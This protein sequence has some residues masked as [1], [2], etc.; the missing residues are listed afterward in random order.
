MGRF[1]EYM[2]YFE[3]YRSQYGDRTTVLYQCGMFY[4][5][6]G[7]E[8]E[9]E[10][11]GHASEIA[12][13]LNIQLTRTDK[14]VLENN[15]SNP[16]MT[17]FPCA[18]IDRNVQILIDNGYTVVIVD[19]VSEKMVGSKKIVT[20]DVT[21]IHSPSTYVNSSR[22]ENY[23]LSI[24]VE[25]NTK[26]NK[27]LY[28]IGLTAIDL[29]TGRVYA[30]QTISKESDLSSSLDETYR[31]VQTF[32]PTE[33]VLS[34]NGNTKSLPILDDFLDTAKDGIVIHDFDLVSRP[35]FLQNS[36]HNHFL[37]SYY[38]TGVL[39]PVQFLDLEMYRSTTV[40]FCVMIQFCKDHNKS[41]LSKLHTPT[42]WDNHKTL[43]LD[44][45]AIN[46]LNLLPPKSGS[47][48]NTSIYG[49]VNETSTSMGRRL[50]KE[51]LL[52]PIINIEELNMRYDYIDMMLTEHEDLTSVVAKKQKQQWYVTVEKLLREIVDVER[53]HRK[54]ETKTLQPSE[55]PMVASGYTATITLIDVIRKNQLFTKLFPE[56]VQK[57][58][59]DMVE[60]YSNVIDLN[61]VGKYNIKDITGNFFKRGYNSNLDKIDDI[62]KLNKGLLE[63]LA[64][65]LSKISKGSA[66]DHVT[67]KCGEDGYYLNTSKP[68]F[69]AIETSF[70]PFV[71]SDGTKID[72]L[73][74]FDIDNRTKTN[75]KIRGGVMESI[76]KKVQ[77]STDNLKAKVL[78]AYMI[79]L[80]DL[81]DKFGWVFAKVTNGLAEL[82]VY[83]SSAK[84][85]DKNKYTRPLLSINT[86]ASF[87]VI[88][89]RH[90]IVEKLET[91]NQYVANSFKLA[92][93]GMLLYGINA[94]GK[95]STMK[96]VGI[97]VVM[98][99]A[100]MYVAAEKLN[101]APFR[102]IMTRILGNDNILKGLSSFAVEMTELR[103]IISRADEYSL[104]LGDE[105]CHG[106]ETYSGI[107][108]V[109]AS[110]IHLSNVG[111]TFIFAT[112][113][114]QLSSMDEILSLKN[115][116]Q[117]HLAAYHDDAT[118]EL[119]YNR[120]LM[121]G[122]GE[123]MYGIEVAKAMKLPKQLIVAATTIRKKYFTNDKVTVSLYNK[124]VYVDKCKIC[125]DKAVETHHIKFQ[126][127]SDNN[128]Y[129]DHQHKNHKSNLV[130]LCEKHHEMVHC[131]ADKE[132]IVFG[133]YADGSLDYTFRNPLRSFK[134]TSV[135]S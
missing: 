68:R 52:N 16:L 13:L 125:D 34:R 44:N 58:I 4:E 94:S 64:L 74:D 103:G 119:I 26:K 102:T 112:H 95:S 120:K 61:E 37:K 127:E 88:N 76:D 132:L 46:Q 128:G 130:Q 89:M 24:F 117:C 62:V 105:I 2:T 65:A 106:T 67:L 33:I 48:R 111:S 29:G 80:S 92:G 6:Y 5:V 31:F 86:Q 84:C 9:H 96:A 42:I 51:R 99:Q 38:S 23:L 59:T 131:P 87:D 7:I 27:V 60:F 135:V 90:P 21:A 70:K 75:T 28:D 1:D 40:A 114:Q 109:A 129:I 113:L 104:V 3:K 66:S 49:I 79:F 82:D 122:S 97:A 19:Q 116:R 10:R 100:G 93:E 25:G 15:R 39:D 20:R 81:S 53:L 41:L 73:T 91:H 107:S 12:T 83:K 85:A 115:V 108:I 57:G 121:D 78:E 45:N 118:D 30:H 35:E 134:P 126:S 36:F 47:A 101:L 124:D 43:V 63:E 22:T 71:L 98:A 69:K 11:L 72:S 133:Y 32:Q 14:S 56:D 123:L 77:E 18:S 55:F 110:L 8:N 17:G 50:L 54:V